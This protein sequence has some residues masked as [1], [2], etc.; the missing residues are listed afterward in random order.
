MVAYGRLISL[1]EFKKDEPDMDIVDNDA[2][3]FEGAKI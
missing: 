2:I 3:L 1:D